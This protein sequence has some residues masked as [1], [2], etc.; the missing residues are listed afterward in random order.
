M[1]IL[2]VVMCSSLAAPNDC[3]ITKTYVDTQSLC[4]AAAEVSSQNPLVRHAVCVQG[5]PTRAAAAPMRFPPDPYR[6]LI[7]G[8]ACGNTVPR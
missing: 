7:C 8:D 5:T 2:Y 6:P 3:Q 1:W 4:E